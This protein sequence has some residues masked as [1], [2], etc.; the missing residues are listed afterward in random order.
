MV[1]GLILDDIAFLNSADIQTLEVL[2]DASATAIY[3][4]RGANGVIIITTKQG[5]LG[6]LKPSV[7][8]SAEY[9]TQ[10][11]S[12]KIDLLNGRQ[13][14]DYVNHITPGSYNN[15]DIVPNTDWQDLIYNGAPLQD[16]QLSVSGASAKSQ[17]YVGVGYFD[18]QGIIDK[19]RYQRL[20]LKLNNTFILSD[21]IKIGNNLT[22]APYTQ[23]NAPGV[24]AT[25]YRAQPTIAPFNPDGSFAEVPGVGNPLADLQYSNNF[26]RGLRT[27]G[28]V[29]GEVT[30]LKGFTFRSSFG[31]DLGYKEERNFTPAFFVSPQQQNEINDLVIKNSTNITWLWENTL[32]YKKTFGKHTIECI[33][34]YTMQEESSNFLGASGQNILG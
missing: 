33:A 12:K 2:K 32:N 3:G 34:G 19:S 5:K 13:F 17:Y 8:F 18:Q 22:F 23:Q 31:V 24:T 20:S 27:V 7:S 14:A 30:F 11:L 15:L 25:A 4:S 21:N 16:Y 28:N 29:F 26:E 9:S 10:M 6:Q 1:D